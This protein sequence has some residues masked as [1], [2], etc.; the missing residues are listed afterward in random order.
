MEYHCSANLHLPDCGAA[1]SVAPPSAPTS[2][3]SQV[4][5]WTLDNPWET[6]GQP[7]EDLWGNPCKSCSLLC[8]LLGDRSISLWLRAF[9]ASHGASCVLSPVYHLGSWLGE[10]FEAR[11]KGTATRLRRN[12]S[13]GASVRLVK[14]HKH[15]QVKVVQWFPNPP[16]MGLSENRVII[17]FPIEWPFWGVYP[18]PWISRHWVSTH[19]RGMEKSSCRHPKISGLIFEKVHELVPVFGPIQISRLNRCRSVYIPL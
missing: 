12:A 9:M 15:H 8:H 7:M 19:R 3:N 18:T 6:H 10:V 5:A 17:M 1:T 16:A 14:A 4:L 11:T 13:K 2:V